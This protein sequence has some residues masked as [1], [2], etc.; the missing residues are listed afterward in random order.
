MMDSSIHPNI[1]KKTN[2]Q[3]RKEEA[4]NKTTMVLLSTNLGNANSDSEV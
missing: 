2:D 4:P 1:E 3:K